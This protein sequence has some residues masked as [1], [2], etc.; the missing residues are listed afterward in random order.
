MEEVC[1]HSAQNSSKT[2]K[3]LYLTRLFLHTQNHPDHYGLGGRLIAQV[4]SNTYCNEGSVTENIVFLY[5]ESSIIG[6]EYTVGSTTSTYYFHR[7]LLGDV[8]ALYDTNGTMVAKYLYDAWGNCTISSET[9]NYAVANANPIRYRGYY[10]DSDT[11]LYYC[12]AR[13]YSPK[14]RRFISPDDTAYLDPES[15]NGLNLYCYCGNDPVNYVDP[16]G[17]EWYNVLGWIG[18]GLVVAAAAV[19]TLGAFGVA[20]GAVIHGAAV[21]ALIGAGAG[22]A[23]GA[24]GGMIYDAVQGNEFG[25]S[26]WA[27]AQAGFGIGAIIGAVAGGTVGYFS[28]HCHSVYISRLE[29]GTVNYVGRTNNIARRTAEHANAGRGVVPQ[30]V[31]KRLTLKQARGLEQALINNYK[32]IKHGGTLI[33]KINSIAAS[34]PIYTEAVAWGNRYMLRH[35]G[36]LL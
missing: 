16:S 1:V 18:L 3:K 2:N 8:V 33:N 24:A 23:L 7:N 21:G 32:M 22:A 30:E 13:Y 17:H 15:V 27:G 5:D 14:W 4:G 26:I 31:A 35:L 25:T 34:N 36:W 10:Y 11:G 28:T 6:M 19:L 20:V 29:D 12:N 9:T